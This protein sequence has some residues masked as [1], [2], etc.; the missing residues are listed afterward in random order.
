MK[1]DAKLRERVLNVLRMSSVFGTLSDAVIQDLA[2]VLSLQTVRGG[3]AVVREGDISSSMLFVISG[4]L[5]ISRRDASGNLL[6]FNEVRPG[7]SFGE[8]GLI[9]QQNRAADVSALRDS[10]LAILHRADYEALIVRHPLELNRVFV[11]AIYNYLRH[12]VQAP[13]QHAESVVVVPL[14]DDV[15]ASE[16]AR[17]LAAAFGKMG[18]THHLS[19]AENR[20]FTHADGESYSDE[21]AQQEGLEGKFAYLVYAAG[22]GNSTWTQRAFRQAD[23]VV[24]V[25]SPNT[26]Q[27][28]GALERQLMQEPGYAMKRRHLVVLHPA[29]TVY[30]THSRN[31]LLGRDVERIYPTRRSHQGD[32]ERLARF[33]TGKAV[34]IV[35]GGGGARG[36]AHLGV[37]KALH[38]AGIAIDLIGGNSMGALIGAQYACD[39]SLDDIR[40]RTQKFAA[41]GERPTLPLISLVSG[42][43]VRRDLI[44][45]FGDLQVDGLWR[46]YFAAACNLT[47]GCTTVQETGP[48]W[49]AVRASNSPAGLF[50]PVLIEGDLLVDGAILE[51]VP[52]AAMRM[53]LGTAQER[54][55]GNGTII[56]VD[57]D[58]QEELSAPINLSKLSVWHTFKGLVSPQSTRT[59]G[60]GQIMYR[61]GHIGGLNKRAQTI[62][63]SD[64]YLEPPVS[65][66]SMMGYR[67]AA[68]IAEVGYRYTI[69]QMA[70]WKR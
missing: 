42:N 5:R 2:N 56:A 69:E 37:L 30:P 28:I 40:E 41:G 43:R 48:L 70:K 65:Q 7:A 24:F 11:Q 6:L 62:G 50:P 63:Q 51:N 44:K 68:E 32:Y 55:R 20:A 19:L 9:L 36:F 38:E 52:V 46:P 39:V 67:N 49:R 59:P 35:L 23:Q 18:A 26:S 21:I 29:D 64:H 53:R 10:T 3:D 57:V 60:I 33:L 61:A 8:A 45:M 17:G 14:D 58:V 15:D 12:N 54:R 31:W 27:D 25:A 13:H 22:G 66:F 1:N 4:A 16:V 34:G 47:K